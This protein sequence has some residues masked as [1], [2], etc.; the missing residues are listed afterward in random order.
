MRYHFVYTGILQTDC[1][2]QTGRTFRYTR[3]GIAVAG[4]ACCTLGSDGAQDIEIE[5]FVHLL[6]KPTSPT[7]R[8]HRILQFNMS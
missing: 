7:R 3:Q 4:L 2:N 5:P 6:T 8:N 1:I